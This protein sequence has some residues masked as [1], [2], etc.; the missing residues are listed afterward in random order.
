MTKMA[1]LVRAPRYD[2][3]VR[4]SL[5]GEGIFET[6]RATTPEA[7]CARP[8]NLRLTMPAKSE[9]EGN[10]R[11]IR[12]LGEDHERLSPWAQMPDSWEG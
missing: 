11:L 10:V 12:A 4:A 6:Y 9:T 1:C 5:A 2:D 8:T 7:D 3:D